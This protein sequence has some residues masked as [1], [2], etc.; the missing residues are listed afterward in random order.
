MTVVTRAGVAYPFTSWYGPLG[1]LPDCLRAACQVL[2]LEARVPSPPELPTFRTLFATA[3]SARSARRTTTSPWALV[4]AGLFCSTFLILGGKLAYDQHVRLTSWQPVV[5]RVLSTTI[6]NHHS[7]NG[8]GRD[9]WSPAVMYVYEVD[10]QPY[11]SSQVLPVNESRSGSWAEHIAD[12]YAPGRSYTAWYNPADPKQ[13]YLLHEAS[14]LPYI[15]LVVPLSIW[16]LML[17]FWSR[18]KRRTQVIAGS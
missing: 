8:K 12:R 3:R 17:F 16:S 4:I 2:E 14:W 10:G 5:V 9:T 1:S 13:A 18:A 6:K 7:R 15:F 11:S